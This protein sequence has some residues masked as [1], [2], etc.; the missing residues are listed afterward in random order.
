[1]E[2]NKSSSGFLSIKNVIRIALSIC[3]ILFFCPM[4]LVSC[5]E[6][7]VNIS[8]LTAIEGYEGYSDPSII[9]L[10]GILLPIGIIVVTFIKKLNDK[11]ASIITV[12]A[13]GTDLLLWIGFVIGVNNALSEVKEYVTVKTT[14]WFWLNLILLLSVIALGVM[15]L[16]GKMTMDTDLIA[17][18]KGGGSKQMLR[19][20]SGAVSRAASNVATGISNRNAR[21]TAIGF[22]QKCGAPIQ[23]GCA[24]CTTC[25]EKVPESLIAAA[26]EKRKAEEAAAEKAR[27]EAEERARI[28]AEERA[29]RMAEEQARQEAARVAQEEARRMQEAAGNAGAVRFCANCGAKMVAESKFCMQCGSKVE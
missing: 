13:A 16:L 8:A 20:M 2:G 10:F 18:F 15:V 3:I 4:C 27:L 12:A 6:Q 11:I 26:E 14:F 7:V 21:E 9:M 1:M 23:Y 17:F 5:N 25:G 19:D 28:E 24:F 22:C 29:R